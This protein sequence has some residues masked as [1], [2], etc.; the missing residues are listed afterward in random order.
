METKKNMWMEEC[1]GNPLGLTLGEY[2]R[3]VFWNI[4]AVLFWDQLN[5]RSLC[6]T[7]MQLS[8][9]LGRS[10]LAGLMRLS[11][12]CFN[13]GSKFWTNF[14]QINS[15]QLLHHKGLETQRVAWSPGLYLKVYWRNTI[16]TWFN[17]LPF[18]STGSSSGFN[19]RPAVMEVEISGE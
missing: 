2:V 5:K 3:V 14:L 12:S 19:Q 8:V 15:L 13:H 17:F 16:K 4:Q 6:S 11:S 7:E 1:K 9:R 18:G 10:W